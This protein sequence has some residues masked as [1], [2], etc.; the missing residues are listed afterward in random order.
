MDIKCRIMITHLMEELVSEVIV[1]V[2]EVEHRVST[3]DCP[4]EL[5]WSIECPLM[6]VQLSLL[7]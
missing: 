1:S 6:T 7:N 3:N 2:R 4:T 5:K